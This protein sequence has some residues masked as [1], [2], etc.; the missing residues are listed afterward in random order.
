MKYPSKYKINEL[1]EP[2]WLRQLILVL[3]LLATNLT[4]A[5]HKKLAIQV[6][7]GVE[8]GWWIHNLGS[9]NPNIP[10]NRGWSRT[11]LALTSIVQGSALYQFK[12][13]RIGAAV[14]YSIFMDDDFRGNEQRVGNF[15]RIEISAGDNVYFWKYGLIAEFDLF[16]NKKAS[17]LSPHLEF[18]TFTED[19][20]HPDNA[21]FGAKYYYVLG[22]NTAIHYKSVDFTFLLKYDNETILMADDLYFNEINEVI[23]VGMNFGMRVWIF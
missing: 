15:D 21:R 12:N 6:E 10:N 3:L 13:A 20:I 14:Q 18:G 8:I 2:F 9:D 4:H 16:K 7:T 1:S 5:Q 23:G 22:L 11:G 19:S 17:F